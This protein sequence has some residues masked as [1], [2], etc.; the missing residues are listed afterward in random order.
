MLGIGVDI[1]KVLLPRSLKQ[2]SCLDKVCSKDVD[3]RLQ[4]LSTDVLWSIICQTILMSN[5][6]LG[7]D[8]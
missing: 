5:L 7:K 4:G 3:D 1:L 2:A 8:R 6:F